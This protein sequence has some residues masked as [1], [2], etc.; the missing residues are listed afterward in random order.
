MYF[1]ENVI[2]K[3]N[4]K[5]QIQCDSYGNTHAIFCNYLCTLKASVKFVLYNFSMPI[6]LTTVVKF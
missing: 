5:E 2:D 1:F 4:H 3:P 6:K